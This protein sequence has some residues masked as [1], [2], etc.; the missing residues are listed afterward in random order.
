VVTLFI[1]II[2]LVFK[3]MPWL[4]TVSR[5]PLIADVFKTAMFMSADSVNKLN[6]SPSLSLF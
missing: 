4:E 2:F 3:A 1:I 5:W 6:A